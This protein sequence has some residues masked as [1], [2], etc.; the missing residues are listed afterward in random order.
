MML[1]DFFK[2]NSDQLIITILLV[3]LLVIIKFA[4]KKST[5]K[6]AELSGYNV[7]RTRLMFKYINFVISFFAFFALLLTWGVNPKDVAWLF[8]S[9][10]AVIGVALFA[11]WSVLSNVTSGVIMFFSF[12]FK[13]GDKIEIHDKDFPIVA[14]IEDIR[15]FQIHLRND[16][17]ELIT[18]PNNL[19]L[20]KSVKLLSK[21]AELLEENSA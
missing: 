8:S 4:V 7:G 3:L 21:E 11:I 5:N 16:K 20:Q 14:I 19:I 6:V 18:Y 15:A 9:T 12:P 2:N 17:N 10:F 13:I 1:F